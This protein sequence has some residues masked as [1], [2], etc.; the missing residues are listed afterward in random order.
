MAA[1]SRSR[2]H[3][4]LRSLCSRWF[5]YSGN[6]G[7]PLLRRITTRTFHHESCQLLNQNRIN[8]NFFNEGCL[9]ISYRKIGYTASFYRRQWIDTKTAWCLSTQ[10][11]IPM[12]S[13][14]R[15]LL[16]LAIAALQPCSL[17]TPDKLTVLLFWARHFPQRAH[18]KPKM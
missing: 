13:V 6:S 9:E 18:L 17:P 1:E 2:L 8:Y 14:R 15:S 4:W 11:G 12:Y 16:L 7:V 3:C 5:W 10:P